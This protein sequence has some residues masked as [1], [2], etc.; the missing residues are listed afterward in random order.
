MEAQQAIGV[1]P[2]DGGGEMVEKGA[3]VEERGFHEP[4]EGQG[5][6][7]VGRGAGMDRKVTHVGKAVHLV[8]GLIG[9]VRRDQRGLTRGVG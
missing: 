1:G 5:E 9:G 7:D 2:A 3:V 6:E 4:G 8:D